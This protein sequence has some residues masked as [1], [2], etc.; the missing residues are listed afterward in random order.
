MK[1][2]FQLKESFF[3]FRRPLSGR[4]T[5]SKENSPKSVSMVVEV[6]KDQQLMIKIVI[7]FSV[8]KNPFSFFSRISSR[9]FSSGK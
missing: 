7:N 4:L 6:E 8:L 2:S 5:K 3:G 9:S 1:N